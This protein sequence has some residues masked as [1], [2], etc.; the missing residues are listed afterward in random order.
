MLVRGGN[1]VQDEDRATRGGEHPGDAFHK[2]EKFASGLGKPR[3]KRG[4]DKIH[5]P[6][7]TRGAVTL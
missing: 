6:T 7:G 1:G 3:G 4:H 2:D 5:F